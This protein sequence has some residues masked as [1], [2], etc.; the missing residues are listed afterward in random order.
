M[1]PDVEPWFWIKFDDAMSKPRARGRGARAA[2]FVPRWV[3][4]L[5]ERVWDAAD[6]HWC[7]Q[8]A[9]HFLA[10]WE[11]AVAGAPPSVQ[12]DVEALLT[13]RSASSAGS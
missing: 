5:G 7:Q 11:A 10:S 1:H 4:W 9:P 2:R 12:P 6:V 8:I 13:E 3:P